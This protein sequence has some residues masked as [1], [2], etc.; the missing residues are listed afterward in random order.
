MRFEEASDYILTK[1]RGELPVTLHYHSVEH[2]LGVYEAA[3]RLATLENI[4]DYEMRLILTAACYHDTGF[5]TRADGHELISCEITRKTLPGYGYNPAEIDQICGM[6]M[7]TRL[8]QTPKNYLEE[9]LADAD[10]DYLGRDDFFLWSNKLN[11]EMKDLGKT[12]AADWN[13]V[14]IDFLEK[15]HYF[16]KSAQNLRLK[17]KAKHLEELK[18]KLKN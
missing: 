14:Q 9:I 5:L 13:R 10:L 12:S 4:D 18:A 6:I 8:P 16:T 11:L 3:K 7:A 17:K 2:T 1:L 15:H